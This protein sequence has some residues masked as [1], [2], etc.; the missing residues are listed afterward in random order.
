[1]KRLSNPFDLMRPTLEATRMMIE[2]QQVI[3]L[4]LAGMAGFWPMQQDEPQ[5]MLDEKLK[6]G[7]ASTVAA[8]RASLAGKSPGDVALAAMKPLRRR[9]RANAA[10]LG[11]QVTGGKG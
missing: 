10:R 5:R 2:A 6:A 7:Q 8:V 3:A 1:M 4:R 11:K 9:T